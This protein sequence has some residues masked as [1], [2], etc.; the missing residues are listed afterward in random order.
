MQ[1][2][3]AEHA[4]APEEWAET[5]LP[6]FSRGGGGGERHGG[7]G[8]AYSSYEGEGVIGCK[9]IWYMVYTVYGIR[10]SVS[11]VLA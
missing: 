8:A 11:L 10:Y 6:L 1:K 3:E 9:D 4:R 5:A 7:D 2:R